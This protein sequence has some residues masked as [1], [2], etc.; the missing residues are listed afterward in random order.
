MMGMPAGPGMPA[1]NMVS[2]MPGAP[3]W[4][5]PMTGTPIGLPGPPH[6]PL[7]GPAG[8]KS[9][10]MRNFTKVDIGKPVDHMLIDVEHRPGIRLPKPVRHIQYTE[11]HPQLA[12]GEAAYPAWHNK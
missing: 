3:S 6:L 11:S 1:T 7:G 8:L 2:G 5:M 10:T 12:P 4:G 9:H